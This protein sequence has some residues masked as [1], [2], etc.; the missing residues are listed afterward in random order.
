MFMGPVCL[1]VSEPSHRV[2]DGKTTKHQ[3]LLSLRNT[4]RN[5]IGLGEDSSPCTPE[6][7]PRKTQ[8]TTETSLPVTIHGVTA[9]E[10]HVLKTDTHRPITRLVLNI[11]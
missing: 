10:R 1:P 3:P 8:N 4:V 5:S 11:Y 2:R 6:N 9:D 7:C